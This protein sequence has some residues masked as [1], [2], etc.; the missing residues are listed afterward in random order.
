MPGLAPTSLWPDFCRIGNRLKKTMKGCLRL[1]LIYH[2]C[3]LTFARGA[4]KRLANTAEYC[5]G[6]TPT[7]VEMATKANTSHSKVVQQFTLIILFF[8]F[9]N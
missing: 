6:A 7:F 3:W 5:L 9:G 2:S 1:G 4:K 8:I